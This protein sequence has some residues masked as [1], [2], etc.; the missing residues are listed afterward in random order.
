MAEE[1][2]S[3]YRIAGEGTA[4]FSGRN[5][6]LKF[7]ALGS[8][9]IVL[10]NLSVYEYGVVQL[11]LS[12]FSIGSVFLLSS[13]NEVIIADMGVL[14]KESPEKMK[15]V[16]LSFLRLQFILSFLAWAALFFIPSFFEKF[17]A[18]VVA[19]FLRVVYFLFLMVPFRSMVSIIF[20]VN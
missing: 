8:A 2:K 10:R 5:V 16:F 19:G 6:I 7:L 15:A 18:A 20:N 9:F 12:V 13:L 1:N 3:L 4:W 11:A 17:V 14:K